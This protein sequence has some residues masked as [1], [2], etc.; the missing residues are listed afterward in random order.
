M[1]TTRVGSSMQ[2]TDPHTMRQVWIDA[3]QYYRNPYKSVGTSRMFIEYMVLDI[4]PVPGLPQNGRYL[5]ADV[6]VARMSDF[7]V[8]DNIMSAR[9][10]LGH[11]LQ[12]GGA[13]P[14][15]TNCPTTNDQT[16]K[17]FI[18]RGRSLD[19]S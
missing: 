17:Q 12:V 4:E 6:Q 9:T 16:I 19:S 18:P 8:N 1:L 14:L 11:H 15:L 2:F 13:V 10:H 7:G 5:L 3:A